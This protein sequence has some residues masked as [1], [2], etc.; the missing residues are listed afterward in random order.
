MNNVD[1]VKIAANLKGLS[2]AQLANPNIDF[3]GRRRG[4]VANM[5]MDTPQA[6]SPVSAPAK[7]KMP[8][9]PDAVK[10]KAREA[11]KNKLSDMTGISRGTIDSVGN[12]LNIAKKQR[13][14][15]NMFGGTMSLGRNS[16][17]G[18]NGFGLS[19]SKNF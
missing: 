19:F 16:D 9:M 5:S 7:E 14:D 12:L 6:K 17:F 13:Y 2:E 3:S 10:R 11:G 1:K 4:V 15:R 18:P 8:L